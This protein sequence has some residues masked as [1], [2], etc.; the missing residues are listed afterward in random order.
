MNV[1]RRRLVSLSSSITSEVFIQRSCRLSIS[2][3][4]RQQVVPQTE[5]DVTVSEKPQAKT[6]IFMLNM[7]GPRNAEEVGPFLQNLFLDRDIIKLPLQEKLG[8]LIAKRR[9]PSIIEKYAEI[10]GGSP[11]YKWT[12]RQGELLCQQL[13]QLSPETAPHKPYVGFRY[14]RPLTEDTLAEM[15]RDGV[16]RIVAFSQYPQYSC[17]TSGSSMNAIYR[18]QQKHHPLRIPGTGISW[19]VIDRWP[20]HPL[21][22]KTFV[23][24]IKKELDTFPPDVRDS[25]VLL[26]SAHSVPLYVMNRGDPYIAEVGAT[27]NLVMQ[28]LKMCNPYRLVWQS[29]VGPLPWLEPGTEATIKALVK[30]GQKNL[31]LIPIAFV[32][33]HI[34]TLHELDIEYADEIGKEVGA[35]RIARCACPND[36]PTFISCLTDLVLT[37]LK[38]DERVS[39]QMLMTCPMCTNPTCKEAKAWFQEAT[40]NCK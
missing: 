16:E 18:W 1:L 32:N 4:S 20:T 17:T 21:L 6:A 37:H 40:S 26:F 7:G 30:R 24:N 23:E 13:D 28:E 25:V 15:E 27:V 11:I 29:K 10:G 39:K 9:T 3:Q 2:Q 22:I 12:T 35:E 31:M 34:E 5:D 36:H 38:S 14:A 8:P 19:S 33:D